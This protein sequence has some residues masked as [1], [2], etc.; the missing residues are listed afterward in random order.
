MN[1]AGALEQLLALELDLAALN[2]KRDQLR[3]FLKRAALDGLERDGAAPR[4]ALRGVGTVALVVPQPTRKVVHEAEFTAWVVRNYPEK[5]RSVPDARW[6]AD[7]LAKAEWDFCLVDS[8]TG[9]A[10]EGAS[11]VP[12]PAYL[13]VRLEKAA[14]VP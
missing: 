11:E 4:W 2:E 13:T 5:L 1:V 10:I 8:D 7:L 12:R 9:V 3:E 14:T 6:T